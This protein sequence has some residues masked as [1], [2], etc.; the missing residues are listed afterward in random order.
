[1]K[2][3]LPLFIT[4]LL[5]EFFAFAQNPS[6]VKKPN[7]VFILMDNLGYG[8]VGCYGGGI[9]RGAQTPLIDRLAAE[10]TRLLNF[11][12]EAQCTSSRSALMTVRF[13]IRSATHSVPVGVG[14][15][16]LRIGK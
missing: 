16:A 13:S 5:F 7:F 6:P 12:V 11:N 2:I 1:M 10:G 8:E 9:T 3:K 4:V 15:K 14:L